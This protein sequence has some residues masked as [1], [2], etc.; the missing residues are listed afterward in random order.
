[1]AALLQKG[2]GPWRGRPGGTP[3]SGRGWRSPVQLGV[4]HQSVGVPVTDEGSACQADE[5]FGV[6]FQLPSHLEASVCVW[7]GACTHL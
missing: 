1:M 4:L 3:G 6:V 7:G 5:A 2:E